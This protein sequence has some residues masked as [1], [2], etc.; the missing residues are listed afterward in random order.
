MFNVDFSNIAV[1]EVATGRCFKTFEVQG[2]VRCVAWCPNSSLS[3]V[4][5][6]VDENVLLINSGVGDRLMQAKTD[7]IMKEALEQIDPS[8]K[9]C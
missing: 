8:G 5:A 2:V 4:A 3:L 9:N 1:W 7:G 6:A